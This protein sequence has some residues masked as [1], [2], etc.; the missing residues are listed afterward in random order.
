MALSSLPTQTRKTGL[1]ILTF[2]LAISLAMT[3]VLADVNVAKA[4][5]PAYSIGH[6]YLNLSVPNA[7]A[8]SQYAGFIASLRAAAGHVYRQGVYTTQDATN[9]LIRVDVTAPSGQV[10]WLWVTPGNLYVRG[11]TSQADGY[12]YYFPDPDSNGTYTWN[13]RAVF[14]SLAGNSLL[15]A[16]GAPTVPLSFNSNYNSLVAAAGRGRESMPI[17]FND[18]VGSVVNLATTNH[19]NGPQNLYVARSLMFMIQYTSEAARFWDTYGVM[20]A[21]MNSSDARYNG[22]PLYQQ[23]IE[24]EWSA[25]SRWGQN[26]TQNPYIGPLYV[27]GVG[28]FYSWGDVV[29]KL[30]IL[31]AYYVAY[32]P[33]GDWNKTEL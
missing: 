29:A 31:L 26:I 23:Y 11:F 4:D 5:T 13:M 21:I 30:A 2:L 8:Q 32:D 9:A 22:L 27:N 14:D 1:R 18:L 24:N 33:N 12:T 20:A 6:V 10:L 3:A 7:T 19:L 16:N 15:P 25:I 28:T 17:S